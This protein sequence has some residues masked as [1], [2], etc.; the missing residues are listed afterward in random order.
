MVEQHVRAHLQ[1]R[2]RERLAF[3]LC[4]LACRADENEL[5]MVENVIDA[6][7]IEVCRKHLGPVVDECNEVAAEQASGRL[8]SPFAGNVDLG[9][10]TVRPYVR[11]RHLFD[12]ARR[13]DVNARE[14]TEV[15]AASDGVRGR[16]LV[17][18]SSGVCTGEAE[19]H[20]VRTIGVPVHELRV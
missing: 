7:F 8:R 15:S 10:H 12:F 3:Q 17:W 5:Y 14:E 13:L 9:S 19:V 20:L 16:C 18:I 2:Q 1:P 6:R 11:Q 4:H